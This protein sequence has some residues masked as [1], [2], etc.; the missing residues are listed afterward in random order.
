M[1]T[2]LNT[3]TPCS[4]TPAGIADDTFELPNILLPTFMRKLTYT[5]WRGKGIT[6][7]HSAFVWATISSRSADPTGQH[8]V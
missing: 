8:T 2:L 3:L 5:E 6:F 4:I 7:C 1:M